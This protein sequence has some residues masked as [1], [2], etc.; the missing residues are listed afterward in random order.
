MSE[1]KTCVKCGWV[2]SG[3]GSRS[4]SNG[5]IHD[6][7]AEP[8]LDVLAVLK[9][10][11]DNAIKS[12]TSIV[13]SHKEAALVIA[14]IKRLEEEAETSDMVLIDLQRKLFAYTDAEVVWQARRSVHGFT[15]GWFSIYQ[16][17]VEDYATTKPNHEVRELLVRPTG[18]TEE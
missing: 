6:C 3:M 14:E 18:E 9:Q 17:E 1:A 7:G 2:S 12:H 8:E 4:C 11:Q 16:S 13:L 5:G 15:F 10:K